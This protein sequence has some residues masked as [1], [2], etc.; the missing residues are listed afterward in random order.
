MEYGRRASQTGHVIVS[1]KCVL[2]CNR[3]E[4]RSVTIVRRL[5]KRH[6]GL[7]LFALAFRVKSSMTFCLNDGIMKLGKGIL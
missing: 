1:M 7:F 4:S 5:H 6:I 2:T 3:A